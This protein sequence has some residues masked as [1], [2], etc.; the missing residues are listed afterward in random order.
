[1]NI[2]KVDFCTDCGEL[3]ENCQCEENEMDCCP[4]CE[5]MMDVIDQILM[6]DGTE[7]ALEI[8]REFVDIVEKSAFDAGYVSALKEEAESLMDF[9]DE[10]EN[11]D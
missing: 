3:A 5:I 1:M 9:A 10:L 2:E 7:E 4:R 6:A 8:L 11:E